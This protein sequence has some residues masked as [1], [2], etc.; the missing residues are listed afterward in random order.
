MVARAS[1]FLLLAAH[2][3]LVS[4]HATAVGEAPVLRTVH[5]HLSAEPSAAP[6]DVDTVQRVLDVLQTL[7]A[8]ANANGIVLHGRPDLLARLGL[9]EGIRDARVSVVESADST[10][11]KACGQRSDCSLILAAAAYGG[12]HLAYGTMPLGTVDSMLELL[13]LLPD[14]RVAGGRVV[15]PAPSK[16]TPVRENDQP[17]RFLVADPKAPFLVSYLDRATHTS[18]LSYSYSWDGPS[19]LLVL[20]HEMVHPLEKFFGKSELSPSS[21]E[22]LAAVWFGLCHG[23]EPAQDD[24]SPVASAL[25]RASS[26]SPVAVN[27]LGMLRNSGLQ[28]SVGDSDE[29]S[30]VMNTKSCLAGLR[31]I[32]W[33]RWRCAVD[34]ATEAIVPLKGVPGLPLPGWC[35]SDNRTPY[36]AL[37]TSAVQGHGVRLRQGSPRPAPLYSLPRPDRDHPAS[38]IWEKGSYN[39]YGDEKF[40]VMKPFLDFAARYARLNT[41]G[42]DARPLFVDVGANLGTYSLFAALHGQDV[43]AYEPDPVNAHHMSQSVLVNKVSQRVVISRDLVSDRDGHQEKLCPFPGLRFARVDPC[44]HLHSVHVTRATHKSSS[45]CSVAG[46]LSQ[47]TSDPRLDRCFDS[48]SVSLDTALLPLIQQKNTIISVLKVAVWGQEG[49]VIKGARGVLSSARPPVALNLEGAY[50]RLAGTAV[51]WDSMMQM[52]TEAGYRNL[53]GLLCPFGAEECRAMRI[54][55]PLEK[56]TATE[57]MTQGT[58]WFVHGMYVELL[59]E[60][61]D[62][63]VEARSESLVHEA[64]LQKLLSSNEAR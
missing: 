52:L 32:L 58:L 9:P 46:A 17:L 31:S 61:T 56:P 41:N 18:L 62:Q 28:H 35:S 25:R 5:V 55:T 29:D 10:E 21:S 22:M 15:F 23:L 40:K 64:Q 43:L 24:V 36:A 45:A 48:V 7:S 3:V 39:S 54:N 26:L 4:S 37:P 2:G 27:L 44:A 59:N 20:D 19:S 11:S 50:E 16:F 53:G 47:N 57:P 63:L 1:P 13:A 30:N 14:P 8:D 6:S 33:G 51:N 42:H 49:I 38:M 34:A 60:W 12:I